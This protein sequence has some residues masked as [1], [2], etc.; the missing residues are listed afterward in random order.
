MVTEKSRRAKDA[1]K[2]YPDPS[3]DLI[4][5]GD[6][7]TLE[8]E[9]ANMDYAGINRNNVPYGSSVVRQLKISVD[10]GDLNIPTVSGYTGTVTVSGSATFTIADGLITD[11]TV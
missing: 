6:G 7:I 4:V 2:G 8:L 11:V 10:S 5:A 3:F 9:N 1:A